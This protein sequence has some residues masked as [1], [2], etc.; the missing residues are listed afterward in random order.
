MSIQIG[1]GLSTQRD[2]ILAAKEAVIKARADIYNAKISLALVFSSI[3]LSGSTTLKVIANF[4]EGAQILGISTE[5][6]FSNQGLFKHGLAV[7]LFSLKDD[8]YITTACVKNIKENTLLATGDSL[9]SALLTGLKKGQRDL[10]IMF[11]DGLSEHGS[12]ITRGFQKKLGASI[13]LLGAIVS[14][15]LTSQKTTIYSNQELLHNAASGLLLG[16]KLVFGLGTQHGW[17]PIGKPHR[18]T[19]SSGN[20]VNEIDSLPAIKL[21]EDYIGKNTAQLKEE[22]RRI[23]IFYP[24][25][26]RLE[27]EKEFL[28]RNISNIKED[29][30]LVLQG[31]VTQDSSVRVMIGTKET[32]LAATAQA[33]KQAKKALGEHPCKFAL[34]FSSLSRYILLGRHAKKELDI[35]KG[36]LGENTPIVGI[37]TH[38]EQAPLV[39]TSYLGSAYLHNQTINVLAIGG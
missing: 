28:L 27:G 26:I 14:S 20:I 31:D 9:A 11:S 4:I 6:I 22:L 7:V 16:G 36:E 24:L 3:D 18:V 23:S 21:Y 19:K 37:Y 12:E 38:A 29:G 8:T 15:G 25:G 1:L 17:L 32:C 10:S 30:S 35:I 5:A 2:P 33:V 13:P 39:A 34:V